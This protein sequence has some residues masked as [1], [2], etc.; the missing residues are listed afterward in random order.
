MGHKLFSDHGNDKARRGSRRGAIATLPC[1]A[2][3]PADTTR[4]MTAFTTYGLDD[5]FGDNLRGRV[6]NVAFGP[7]IEKEHAS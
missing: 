5:A 3:E 7:G 6:S 1:N 4:S 2:A